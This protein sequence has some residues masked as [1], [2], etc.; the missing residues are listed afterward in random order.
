[1]Q[2]RIWLEEQEHQIFQWDFILIWVKTVCVAILPNQL[3]QL[4]VNQLKSIR[5][6]WDLNFFPL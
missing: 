5:S 1:M 6:N 3:T 4:D 2:I